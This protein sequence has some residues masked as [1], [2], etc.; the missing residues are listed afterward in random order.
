M[1]GGCPHPLPMCAG[2][3]PMLLLLLLLLLHYPAKQHQ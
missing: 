3:V 1:Q 2:L